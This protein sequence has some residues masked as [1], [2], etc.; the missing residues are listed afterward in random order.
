MEYDDMSNG[1][2][3]PTDVIAETDM[4]DSPQL[5]PI[6]ETNSL[7]KISSKAH[8]VT[9]MQII[10]AKVTIQGIFDDGVHAPKG[11]PLYLNRDLEEQNYLQ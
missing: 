11:K 10:P 8:Q 7:Q 2:Q 3:E 6:V 9:H 4:V 1:G 5:D